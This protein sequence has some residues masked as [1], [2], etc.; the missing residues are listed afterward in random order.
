ML[1]QN[2]ELE[3]NLEL[4][5]CRNN[6]LSELLRKAG[7]T[8]PTKNLYTSLKK[9]SKNKE[10]ETIPE[11]QPEVA[12]TEE[13]NFNQINIKPTGRPKKYE[14]VI[15]SEQI[16]ALTENVKQLTDNLEKETAK[17]SAKKVS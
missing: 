15:T 17:K 14:N 12:K 8:I 6:Q 4:L 1:D 11:K 13:N 9:I 2:E 16:A 5:R 3:E 7:I 10:N